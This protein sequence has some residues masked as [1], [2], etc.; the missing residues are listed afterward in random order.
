MAGGQKVDPGKI[1]AAGSAYNTEGGD[2][3]AAGSKI[4]TGVSM[5]QVGKAW[6]PV[7]A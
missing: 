2:L 4:E 1:N 5:G 3:V 7:A 6:A